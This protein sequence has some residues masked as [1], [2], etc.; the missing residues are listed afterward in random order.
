MLDKVCGLQDTLFEELGIGLTENC[1][2]TLLLLREKQG[3][4][5][6]RKSKEKDLEYQEKRM[7]FQLWAALLM[8]YTY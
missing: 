4:N 5:Y 8:W 1:I 6:G 2:I 7:L 3:N